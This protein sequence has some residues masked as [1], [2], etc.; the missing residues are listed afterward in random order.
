MATQGKIT[1]IYELKTVGFEGIHTQFQT[2]SDDLLKIKKLILDLQGKSVGL[3]GDDLAKVNQQ[4][5]EA[6]RLNDEL[7]QQAAQNNQTT[8][9]S[10]SK[11]FELNKAYK[12]AKNNAQDL[13]AEYGVESDQAKAAAES[14]AALKQQLIDINDLIKSA[15]KAQAPV[16]PFAPGTQQQPISQ[17]QNIPSPVNTDDLEK[18]KQLLQETGEAVSQVTTKYEQYTGTLRE[19]IT[20]QI[21]NNSQLTANR[22]A[23]KEIQSAINAQGSATDQQVSKLAAL[24]EQEQILVE[25]NKDLTVTIRN[26]TKEFIAATGSLDEMQA[27]LN[28]LQQSYE[29]LSA[30]EKSSPIGTQ[31]KAEID[32]LE[33]KVKDLE[34]GIGKFGRNVG[35]YEGSAKIIVDALKKVEAEIS[36]LQQKQQGLVDY[37]K[38]NEIGFK[39]GGGQDNLNQ[40]NAQLGT[41]QKQFTALT[42]ITSNPQFLNIASKVGDNRAEIRF[43]TNQLSELRKE[44]LD[45]SETF[46]L[47]EARLAELTKDTRETRESIKALSSETRT[48][49]LVA[50]GFRGISDGAQLFVG[51]QTLFGRSSEQVQKSLQTLLAVQNVATGARELANEATQK[52]TAVNKAY[53]FVLTNTKNLF[54]ANTSSASKWLSVLK[55]GIAG[56]VIG[57]IILLIQ[58][59]DKL[60]DKQKRLTEGLDELS[61]TTNLTKDKLKEYGDTISKVSEGAIKTLDQQIKSFNDELGRSPSI[62]DESTAAIQLNRQEVNRLSASLD[63][64][65]T[66]GKRSIRESL[67]NVIPFIGGGTVDKLKEAQ[68]NLDELNK[69]Q[70]Q[71]KALQ[72]EVSIDAHQ[73]ADIESA[74]TIAELQID[75]NNRVLNNTKATEKQKIQAINSSYVQRKQIIQNNLDLELL[76]NKN[77]LLKQNE[78]RQKANAELIKN[79]RDLLDQLKKVREQGSSNAT[80]NAFKNI[81]TIRDQQLAKEEIKRLQNTEDEESYLQNIFKINQDAINKKLALIKGGN[82]EERKQIAQL[83]LDKVKAEHDTNQK[84]FDIRSN[85]LKQQLDQ[86]IADIE[87]QRDKELKDPTLTETKRVEIKLEADNKILNK[88]ETFNQQIEVLEKQLG[89]TTVNNAKETVEATKKIKEQIINDEFESTQAALKDAQTAG[90]KSIVA[91]QALMSKL[92]VAIF[93]DQDLSPK[94]RDL[95]LNVVDEQQQFGVLARAVDDAQKQLPIY[96]QLLEEKK[97]TDIQYQEFTTSLNEK[98]LQLLEL[99]LKGIDGSV[100]KVKVIYKELLDAGKITKEEYD[101][102]ISDLDGTTKKAVKNSA[103]SIKSLKDVLQSGLSD[104]FNIDIKTDKGKLES[105]A[106]SEA[107]QESY[108]LATQAMNSYFDAEQQ[109]IQQ[110]LSITEQRIDLE[111]QQ[112]Q[113]RAQSQAEIDTIEKQAAAKKRDAQREA[114]EQLKRVR[115]SEAK[116]ALATQLVNVAVEASQYPFP[117]NLIIGAILT[118]LALAN[119]S[120]Q[121]GA[122]NKEQ[123]AKGGQVPKKGGPITGPSHRDGGIPISLKEKTFEVEGGEV[124][125]NKRSVSDKTIRTFT[126][127]NIQILSRIN[128]LGGGFDFQPGAKITKFAGGGFIGDS[129]QAPVYVPSALNNSNNDQ[130]LAAIKEQNDFIKQ[131]IVTNKILA[132]EQSER[133]DRLQVQL[134]PID[135]TKSQEKT[136]KQTSVGSL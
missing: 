129:L 127:T 10:I 33:P 122:I 107:L 53:N 63:N 97:I 18:Q 119:Y 35:N 13:A 88:Q 5:A 109:R 89:I 45:T 92:K 132:Q 118:G 51:A 48:L 65:Q 29:Q 106:I 66:V 11:Y 91:F 23:Q 28:Q 26:Q 123:F 82:A 114:G 9:K 96:K 81:D 136:M 69:K 87:L 128:K 2:L 31:L 12:E 100:D 62:L 113:A 55:L 64:F 36:S 14:A 39:I 131:S 73:K 72:A 41:L 3:K 57:G 61:N 102:I 99:Y 46:R 111:K 40:V 117:A 77:D 59:L 43:F 76:A 130:L 105:A 27:Q 34:A 22:S 79:N 74:N 83:Q 133:V 103:D 94:Q 7:E 37:S 67:G 112:A 84:L 19:N 86:E 101:K 32:E 1:K 78:A 60:D 70:Q 93:Q 108:N 24:R 115:K 38:R 125:V 116:I 49:D 20:A 50:S 17:P 15:G 80:Q 8:D 126:G 30:T 6:L 21:E 52:G 95:A 25:T 47:I 71:Y 120:I 104:L 42:G 54:D 16:I 44:G 85:A 90:Q 4:L 134:N 75:D 68:K 58:N 135:V 98:Q 56:A 124:I 110:S 121:V